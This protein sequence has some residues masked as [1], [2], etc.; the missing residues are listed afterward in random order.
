MVTATTASDVFEMA[1]GMERIGM[2]FYDA[3]AVSSENAEVR[4]F[5]L[6]AARDEAEHLEA[7]RLMRDTW[8]AS[9]NAR[10]TN[11]EDADALAALA[12]SRIQP[13][14][15]TA[16][17]VAIGGT[18]SQSLA[19]AIQ[20]ETDAIAYYQELGVRIPAAADAIR[21]IVDMEKTHLASLQL[22]AA[23]SGAG[24]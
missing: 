24:I 23:G 9:T 10:R 7:F 8:A 22:L 5:C 12:K 16:R 20:M 4:A 14:A 18:V 3:L 17:K 6:K 2:D 15:A 11:P 13:N 21:K 1:I 19:M